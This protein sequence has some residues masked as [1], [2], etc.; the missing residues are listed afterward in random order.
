MYRNLICGVHG[1]VPGALNPIYKI[2][3]L[4]NFYNAKILIDCAQLVPH[5]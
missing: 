3:I 5:I 4:C 1:N 2:A